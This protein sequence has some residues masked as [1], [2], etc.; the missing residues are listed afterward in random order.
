MNTE[1]TISLDTQIEINNA[2]REYRKARIAVKTALQALRN[3]GQDYGIYEDG[4]MDDTA[5]D[6][7]QQALKQ[8]AYDE[9]HMIE[10]IKTLDA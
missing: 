8:L 4:D 10:M 3:L 1:T 5:V 7:L 2:T 9:E 6:L